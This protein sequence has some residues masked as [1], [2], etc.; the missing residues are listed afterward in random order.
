MLNRV[1]SQELTQWMAYDRIEPIGDARMDIRFAILAAV[2][3]NTSRDPGVKPDPFLYTDFMPDFWKEPE[4]EEPV[5][6]WRGFLVIAE[7][8]TAA[9]GGEDRRK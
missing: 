9:M 4:V 2:V 1:S 6:K 8:V 3:A 7:A 5:E